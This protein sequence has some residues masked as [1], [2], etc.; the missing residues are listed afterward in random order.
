MFGLVLQHAVS[1]TQ[2]LNYYKE[3][4]SKV[5]NMVGTEKANAIF[6]GA[7]HLLSAGSSDFIQNYYV[8]PLLYRTYSPQQFSDILITSFSNFIQVSRFFY[9]Y[10]PYLQIRNAF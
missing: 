10:F 4:Q 1:L 2:Q 8:N 9:F 3:Y 5:V 7:I 6:S